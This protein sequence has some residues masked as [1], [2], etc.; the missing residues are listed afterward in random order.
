MY[1]SDE[2]RTE[3]NDIARDYATEKIIT[4]EQMDMEMVQR[5]FMPISLMNNK[6]LTEFFEDA[7][8]IYEYASR[9]T[10][11]AINGYLTFMSVRKITNDE[12]PYFKE[13]YDHYLKVL[14]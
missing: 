4:N 9:A 7:A 6:Q 11:I 14:T 8:I 13:R 5:V 2:K 3:I 12:F 1:I 10:P